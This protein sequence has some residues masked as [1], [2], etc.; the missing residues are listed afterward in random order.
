MKICLFCKK[1][2]KSSKFHPYQFYCSRKCKSKSSLP[3]SQCDVCGVTF[4]QKRVNNINY[5]SKSCKNL[6]H[7]RKRH[8]NPIKG[9][10]KRINGSGY[11]TSQ[12]YK[13]ISKKHPNSSKRGQ[14]FEHVYI[15]SNHI[16]RPLKKGE[17]VHH[18][19]GE[20]ADNRIENLEL[21][22]NGHPFGQRLDDKIKWAK[23]FLA[24][25]GHKVVPNT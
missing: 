15:L 18:I 7:S 6:A 8:G 4:I 11:I 3:I 23:E 10:K 9:L 12:G 22:I 20:R 5:C 21:W 17:T 1:E 24:E 2:F 16:G 19:N 14:I 13:M 25:Y